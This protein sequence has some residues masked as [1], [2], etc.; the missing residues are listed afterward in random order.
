MK[1]VFVYTMINELTTLF[2]NKQL[3][4]MIN[5]AVSYVACLTPEY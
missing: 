5:L 4:K 1:Y 2:V 3:K